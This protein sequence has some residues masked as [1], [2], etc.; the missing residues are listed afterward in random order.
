M[1][2]W[3]FWFHLVQIQSKNGTVSQNKPKHN[4]NRLM[5]WFEL[6]QK[7]VSQDTQLL[8]KVLENSSEEQLK[9]LWMQWNAGKEGVRFWKY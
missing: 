6:K 5:F 8:Y 3:L 2:I 9:N 7:S 1:F 4:R